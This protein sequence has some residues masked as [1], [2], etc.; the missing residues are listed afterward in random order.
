M[1][2]RRFAGDNHK[3]RG[4]LGRLQRWQGRGC[5]PSKG[6]GA[7]ARWCARV[8]LCSAGGSAVSLHMRRAMRELFMVTL[9][10]PAAYLAEHYIYEV[11][12]LRWTY[13]SLLNTRQGFEA[14][15]LI[16]S[17]CVH[18]RALLDFYKSSP[19][20]DDIVASFFVSSGNFVPKNTAALPRVLRERINKQ[21]A[22]LTA[23]REKPLKK[24]DGADRTALISA[25]EADHA[26]FKNSVD[27][28]YLGCFANELPSGGPQ[29]VVGGSPASATGH[30]QI[31]QSGNSS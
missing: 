20:G 26:S 18:A 22:H 13:N 27:S 11:N 24:I 8:L 5:T 16:E 23:E 15:A 7:F 29:L 28:Q 6:R 3:L 1:L 14:N 31:H 12:M 17:F 4:D 19:K 9:S 2:F 10:D 30:I 21:I 25:I